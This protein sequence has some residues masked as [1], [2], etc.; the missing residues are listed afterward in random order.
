MSP[1]EEAV[2]SYLP[3]PVEVLPGKVVTQP[4]PREATLSIELFHARPRR[5]I[6]P[7][8]TRNPVAIIARLA[9]SG[10]TVLVGGSWHTVNALY[11]TSACEKL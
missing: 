10:V 6:T 9:G 7:P 3:V 1:R 4:T 2:L 11:V 5:A 8:I